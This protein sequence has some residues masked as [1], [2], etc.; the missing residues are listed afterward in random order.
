MKIAF[1]MEKKAKPAANNPVCSVANQAFK[2]SWRCTVSIYTSHRLDDFWKERIND[3]CACN[4]CLA[5]SA[6][7]RNSVVRPGVTSLRT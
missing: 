6:E 5:L 1:E 3:H 4:D 7:P 2:T